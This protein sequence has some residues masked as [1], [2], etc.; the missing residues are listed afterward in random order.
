M[1][2]RGVW[3]DLVCVAGDTLVT[4]FALCLQRLSRQHILSE[5]MLLTVGFCPQWRVWRRNQKDDE[6]LGG[7]ALRLVDL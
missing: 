5:V 6:F 2:S 7:V 3:V 4:W 1:G